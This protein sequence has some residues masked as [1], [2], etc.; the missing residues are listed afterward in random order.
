MTGFARVGV[1]GA[2]LMGAGIAQVA[3]AAGHR[4]VLRDVDAGALARARTGI[5][6]SAAKLLEKGKLSE[7]AAGRI[8]TGIEYTTDL[9][10]LGTSDLVIEAVPEVL[11]V[12]HD[13]L[14]TVDAL[15]PPDAVLASNTSSLA[16]A[17]LAA[18]TGRADR[19]LGLH[20]FNPVPLM[21]LVEVVRSVTTA[22][23]VVE[24]ATAFVR[25]LGKEPVLARDAPGFVVN[26][27]LVPYLME[28]VRAVEAGLASVHD[29]DRAMQLGAGHPMG[30]LTLLDLIGLDTAVHAAEALH[31]ELQAAHCAPPPLLRR[32]VSAG[33]LGRKSG[34]GFY[35]YSGEVPVPLEHV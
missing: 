15:L 9:A 18:A 19:F 30:P 4:V 32:L 21:G 14:K 6:R 28:A 2:G 17:D 8:R 1:V 33:R 3:A 29:V 5:D 24:R 20:F 35:D 13:V 34:S 22:Q 10:L 16:I 31:A 23:A 12:K 25:G 11:A 27:L 26:R 7:E